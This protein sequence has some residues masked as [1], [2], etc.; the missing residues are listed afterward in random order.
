M[1]ISLCVVQG[2]PKEKRLT[3]AAGIY[4]IGSGSECSLCL[5]SPLVDRQHCLIT[6]TSGVVEVTDLKSKNG[7]LVNGQRVSACPLFKG[8]RLHIG[9]LVLEL[10]E[11]VMPLQA[12]AT[13]PHQLETIRN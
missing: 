5:N 12:T 6:I 11:V 4:L 8:D 10:V 2:H 9:P 7:T 13:L 3:F 1:Q